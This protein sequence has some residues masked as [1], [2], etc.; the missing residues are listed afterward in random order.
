MQYINV[1]YKKVILYIDEP[2]IEINAI[3]TQKI[4]KLKEMFILTKG[5][6]GKEAFIK[7]SSIKSCIS[8]KDFRIN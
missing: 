4:D 8:E 6:T 3:N 2:L 7:L 5:V 1:A